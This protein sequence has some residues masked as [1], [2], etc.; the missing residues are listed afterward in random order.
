MSIETVAIK[1]EPAIALLI[2]AQSLTGIGGVP[3]ATALKVLDD[4]ARRLGQPL[5]SLT[6]NEAQAHV[7]NLRALFAADD[8]SAD[9]LIGTP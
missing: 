5:P 9:A 7:D 1:I 4:V 6:A 2:V 3:A 8:V